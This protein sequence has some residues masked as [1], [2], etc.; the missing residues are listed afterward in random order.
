LKY[1]FTQ[2]LNFELIFTETETEGSDTSDS[3]P[4]KDKLVARINRKEKLQKELKESLL[5]KITKQA[6]RREQTRKKEE[7]VLFSQYT[8]YEENLRCDTFK[9]EDYQPF[10]DSSIWEDYEELVYAVERDKTK[11][12]IK[13]FETEM[14]TPAEAIRPTGD[15]IMHVCAEYGRVELISYFNKIGGELH[16]RNYADEFPLHLAA[17]EGQVDVMTYIFEN[18][19]MSIDSATVDGW[20][21]FHY[22]VNNGYLGAVE[23]LV[24]KGANI[25]AVDKFKRSA[26]HWAVRYDFKDIVLYLLGLSINLELK[27]REG[28]TALDIAKSLENIDMMS[29]IKD[30][31][32]IK[33]KDKKK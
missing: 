30:N 15:N 28:R 12:A 27:D 13:V 21:P 18:S 32:K 11:E 6:I 8:N 14:M 3:E 23:Y 16:S 4:T 19:P 9:N 5:K 22:A 1:E 20:T 25:N 29:L 2:F 7:D 10:F 17:R 24:A 26:L 31:I 33:L